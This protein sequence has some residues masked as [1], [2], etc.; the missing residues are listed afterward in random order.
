MQRLVKLLEGVWRPF[1][2]ALHSRGLMS[3]CVPRG[4]RIHVVFVSVVALQVVIGG[5]SKYFINGSA[6]QASRVQ[7]LFHSVQ[8]NVNNP[9]F[10]IMQ[11]RITKVLNMKPMEVLGMLEEAAGTRMYEDKK[12]SAQRVIEKKETKVAEINTVLRDE[13][14]PTLSKLR[15]EQREYRRHQHNR[16]EIEKLSRLIA[17]HQWVQASQAQEQSAAQLD[18][19]KALAAARRADA[20]RLRAEADARAAEVRGLEEARRSA[21]G[22]EYQS[23]VELESARGKELVEAQ[24]KAASAAKSLAVERRALDKAARAADEAEGA[25]EALK[26]AMARQEAADSGAREAEAKARAAYQAA[27]AAYEAACTGMAAA[28]SLAGEGGGTL[29]GRMMQAR[30][31]AAG[32]GAASETAAMRAA[33]LRGEAAAAV[34]GL[35]AGRKEF[36]KLKAAVASE[37]AKAEA[38]SAAAGRLSAAHD[39]GEERSLRARRE[40]L[41]RLVAAMEAS[42]AKHSSGLGSRLRFDYDRRAMGKRW[43]A[44]AVRGVVAGLVRVTDPSAATALEVTAGGRLWQVVVST[45]DAGK[46]LLKH[47]RLQRRVTLIPLDKVSA[48]PL[49]PARAARAASITGGR[50]A[51][52]ISYVGYPEDVDAAVQHVFGRSLVCEDSEAARACAF[53][54]Q[55]R[56]VSVTKEGDVFDPAGTL[57]GGS[58]PKTAGLLV[59]LGRIADAQAK[60]EATRAELEAAEARL[61]ELEAAGVALEEAKAEADVAAHRLQLARARLSS[62]A[63]ADAQARA[64]AAAAEAEAQEAEA[65]AQGAE[66]ERALRLLAELDGEA[67]DEE[68]RR[69]REEGAAQK[70]LSRAKRALAKAEAAAAKATSSAEERAMELERAEA[71]RAEAARARE[72][73]AEAA[74]AAQAA[75]AAANERVAH[76]TV[77]HSEAAEALAEHRERVAETDERLSG[78]LSARAEAERGAEEAKEEADKAEARAGKAEA[79]R[80][81]GRKE[82][83]RLE[84]QHPWIH[85]ERGQF[86]KVA[87]LYDFEANPVEPARERKAELEADQAALRRRINLDAG[88]MLERAETEY[89]ALTDKRERIV[90]DRRK[91]ERVIAELDRKKVEALDTTWTRVNRD[92]ASIFSTLLPGTSS[93]L[94]PAAAAEEDAARAEDSDEETE[95]AS[96]SALGAAAASA[97]ASAGMR[98]TSTDLSKGLEIRVAFNGVWKESLTELS[99]GQRSLLALSLILAMLLFKPAPVYILDEVDAALDLSHTQNIGRMLRS[100]FKGSQFVVVSLKQGMFSNANTIFRTKFV[101]G[102]S[103]VTRTTG[104]R[105]D[106]AGTSGED[107]AFA[108]AASKSAQAVHDEAAPVATL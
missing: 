94:Y 1:A 61:A 7:T 34:K 14:N 33:H 85:E 20:T 36:D 13:I 50:A 107:V 15:A 92:F 48:A 63:Y 91:I 43:D 100:H 72:V 27:E 47:G 38:A 52:A 41:G 69:E 81:L 26:A 97:S 95:G 9:H 18:E 101:D 67:G 82:A 99:G 108:A 54:K 45:A 23:V 74:Q 28:G 30:E 40:E 77:A 16:E 102:V 44:S 53:D 12:L 71:E 17:A 22:P 106:A 64:D 11:G 86:G 32:A 49:D 56:C 42:L 37:G 75:L 35:A 76:A 39:A 66:R 57:E 90:A 60:L 103:T 29:Q 62:C 5:R 70:E 105:P 8:L 79:A 65:E 87:T 6:A 3:A 51:P 58:R 21:M 4:A 98:S 84:K 96:S 88:A 46:A 2:L 89:K 83:A 19:L 78:V 93:R 25:L 55:V 80:K 24:A 31:A 73:A 104:H 68:G 59:K 10:L